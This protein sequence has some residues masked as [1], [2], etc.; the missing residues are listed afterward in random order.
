MQMTLNQAIEALQRGEVVAFPTETVYG[1]GGSISNDKALNAIFQV[2]ER[3]FFDPLIVHIADFK[4]ITQLAK[5][6]SPLENFLAQKFWPGP[7]TFVTAKTEHVSDLIT[8]GLP[9]VALRM[10]NH[11]VA[12]ELLKQT[13]PL[14][15]PSAN[16]F[17]RTSPTSAPHVEDE[18]KG[19]IGVLDGGLCQGGI[20]ST[21]IHVSQNNTI[22]ILRLGLIT[23][24]HLRAALQAWTGSPVHI[25]QVVAST[26]TP[27]HLPHHYQPTTPLVLVNH[28]PTEK[29]LTHIQH[30]LQ[31]QKTTQSI[32]I[33]L[34]ENATTA[35]RELY[36]KLR[37]ASEQQADFLWLNISK[38]KKTGLWSAIWD[39]LSKAQS[40][41]LED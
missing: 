38:I 14:A 35:A 16:K 28:K 37:S 1:L 32:E 2:K 7:L 10:P 21:V 27:G 11:P 30:Q 41:I 36:A 12:L 5:A 33:V 23:E 18:F 9:T 26:A 25:T 15:A 29:N 40:L 17:G 31:L 39:R 3:P 20:E 8:S 19:A 24:E 13:G 22:E 34:S 6:W 4:Q